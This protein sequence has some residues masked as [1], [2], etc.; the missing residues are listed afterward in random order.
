[1]TAERSK[2]RETDGETEREIQ[3]ER[4]RESVTPTKIDK[5]RGI[6][7]ATDKSKKGRQERK[8]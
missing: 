5:Y 2:D 3:R 6:D 7:R 8:I 1:V 4:R